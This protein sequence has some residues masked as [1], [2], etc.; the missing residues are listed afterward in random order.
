MKRKVRKRKRNPKPSKEDLNRMSGSYVNDLYWALLTG[1]SEDLSNAIYYTEIGSWCF[2]CSNYGQLYTLCTCEGSTE[3]QGPCEDCNTNRCICN[4]DI[5]K[6]N[7]IDPEKIRKQSYFRIKELSKLTQDYI[8]DKLINEINNIKNNEG[9]L[10]ENNPEIANEIK[11]SL[12][13]KKL[14]KGF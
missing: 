8:F 3:K 11:K 14:L 12:F 10:V 9:Y 1:N 2:D 4:Q 5:W 13:L 7:K 6:N